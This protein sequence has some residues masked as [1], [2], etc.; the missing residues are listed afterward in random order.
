M[1]FEAIMDEVDVLNFAGD[2]IERL[3]EPSCARIRSSG[4]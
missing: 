4:R 1:A 2:R 3:A